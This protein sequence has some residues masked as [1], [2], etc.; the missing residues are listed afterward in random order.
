[1]S[2]HDPKD[3]TSSEKPV[4]NFYKNLQPSIKGKRIGLIK[5]FTSGQSINEDVLKTYLDSIEL[6]KSEGA[7]IVELSLPLTKYSIPIYYLIA[8]S[9]ASSNLSRY[10]GV[11]YGYRASFDNLSGVNLEEFYSKTRGEGFGSEVIRR[12]M[13]GTYCLSAGYYEAY[14][15]KASRLRRMLHNQ[16]TEAFNKCDLILSPVCTTPAFKL[17]EKTTD[18][19]SMY[20][21]DIY[22]VATNLVGLPGISVPFGISKEKLP[23]GVQLMSPHFNEQELLNAALLLEKGRKSIPEVPDVFA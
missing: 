23:I 21:N 4:P 15:D 3:G 18:P 8:S 5:E 13:L 2:G 19:L 6:L 16:F 7:E 17:G 1:M 9:E 11:K 10:D 22:T 14:Y 12:I 20:L